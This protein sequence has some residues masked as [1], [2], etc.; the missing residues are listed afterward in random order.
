MFN[1]SNSAEEHSDSILKIMLIEFDDIEYIT[2]LDDQAQSIK[3]QI[4]VIICF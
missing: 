3:L 1:R 4:Q 2:I